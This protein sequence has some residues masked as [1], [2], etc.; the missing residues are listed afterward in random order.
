VIT[1]ETR[2][3]RQKFICSSDAAALLDLDPFRSKAQVWL[4]KTGRLEDDKGNEATARGNYL[5]GGILDWAQDLLRIPL[6]R[7]EMIVARDGIRAANLDA[8]VALTTPLPAHIASPF[9][10]EAK[11]TT[12]T[13]D[14][15]AEETDQ[16][17]KHVLVQT[18]HQ[19]DVVGPEYELIFVPVLMPVVVRAGHAVFEFKSYWVRRNAE[20]A[21]IIADACCTF[22]DKYVKTDTPPNDFKPPL[23]VLKRMRRVPKRTIELPDTAIATFEQC[24]MLRK[25]KSVAEK[26]AEEAD[27]ALIALLG[28]A[29]AGVLPDG[30][31]FTYLEQTQQRLDAKGLREQHPAI[32]EEFEKPVTFRQLREKSSARTTQKLIA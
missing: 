7:H 15:G 28:D 32:A 18:H 25:E 5:E 10:V 22:M 8:R 11:S 1:P 24:F 16:V 29:E 23:E 13:D 30:R 17:P 6:V 31:S 20:L 12:N 14:Y 27:A 21:R 19:A 3:K 9:V 4:E 26:R 2:A